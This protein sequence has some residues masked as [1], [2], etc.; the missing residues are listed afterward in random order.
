MKIVKSPSGKIL[1][2]H[3]TAEDIQDGLGFFSDDS[4]FI[5]I[6]T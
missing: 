3:I 6:G 4:D 5:Q 1:A 2:K